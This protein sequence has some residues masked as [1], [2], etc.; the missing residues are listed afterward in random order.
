MN[1]IVPK[2]EE[3]R[4]LSIAVASYMLSLYLLADTNCWNMRKV[5]TEQSNNIKTHKDLKIAKGE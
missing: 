4:F 2:I 5:I 3:I 1:C